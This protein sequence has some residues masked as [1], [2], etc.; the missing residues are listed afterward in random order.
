MEGGELFDRIC[1]KESYSEREAAATLKP[2][3]DAIKFCHSQ[4]VVHR[5]IKV[6][7]DDDRSQ[8]IY[9]TSRKQT[10]V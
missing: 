9:S 3:V 8:R 10:T 2:V 5:D 4:G 7:Q 1:E 6:G